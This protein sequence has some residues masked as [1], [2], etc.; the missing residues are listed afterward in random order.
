MIRNTL[1][2]STE[3]AE[4]YFTYTS[5]PNLEIHSLSGDSIFVVA[6]VILN[7]DLQRVV[8]G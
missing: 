3:A 1:P 2:D 8:S 7:D 5:V 4:Y 6:L